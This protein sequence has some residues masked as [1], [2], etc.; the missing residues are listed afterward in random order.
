M[1]TTAT[2]IADNRLAVTAGDAAKLVGVSRSQWWRLH[3]AGKVPMPR[4]LGVKVA[5][6]VGARARDWLAA[7]CPDRIVWQ[8]QRRR[9][10]NAKAP[11]TLSSNEPG[12]D[13]RNRTVSIPSLNSDHLADLR[14]SGLTDDTICACGFYS[15]S[16]PEIVGKLL[17][18]KGP[19]KA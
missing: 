12:Q 15:E 16:A 17:K 4:Y 14:C 3:S 8:K 2:P 11:V 10:E 6:M 19:A 7:G 5:A 9:T 13:Q 1:K 18:W